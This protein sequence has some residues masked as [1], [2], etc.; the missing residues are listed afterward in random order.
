MNF[1][2]C[3]L[4]FLLSFSVNGKNVL[5][6]RPAKPTYPVILVSLDGFRAD[7]FDKF[8]AE[9]PNSHLKSIVSEGVKADYMKY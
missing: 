2:V 7:K 5:G 6:S 3:Y 4:F 8:I 9:N 1:L